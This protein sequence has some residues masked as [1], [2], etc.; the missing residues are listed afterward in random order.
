MKKTT[1]SYFLLFC[2]NL[3]LAFSAVGQ[4]KIPNAD[5][6]DWKITKIKVVTSTDTVDYNHPEKWVSAT[7]MIKVGLGLTASVKQ[8]T[9]SH[10]GVSALET[11][12]ATGTPFVEAINV[13][14]CNTKPNKVRGFY[15]FSTISSD[16]I[17]I[18]ATAIGGDNA[19]LG[20]GK[21]VATERTAGY[22]AFDMNIIYSSQENIDSLIITI[23]LKGNGL[24]PVCSVFD[25]FS[26]DYSSGA[27]DDALTAHAI[28]MGP[29]PFSNQLFV[30][31]NNSKNLALKLFDITG[32]LLQTT[33]IPTSN[34]QKIDTS[35][36]NPGLYLVKFE[37]ESGVITTKKFIKQNTVN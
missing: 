30:K 8:S 6:E 24:L 34:S 23:M 28:E 21:F 33:H 32:N 3:I 27:K 26:L 25:D 4:T 37:D 13:F 19:I 1:T 35:K 17:V 2:F 29:N 12:L 36:L 9:K 10:A 15:Q 7:D 20:E 18:S 31:N 5:F 22:K 14:S 16:T 11:C